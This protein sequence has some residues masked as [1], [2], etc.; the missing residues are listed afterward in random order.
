[1]SERSVEAI[2]SQYTQSCSVN[3]NLL[4]SVTP[5]HQ[6]NE[7]LETGREKSQAFGI[8]GCLPAVTLYEAAVARALRRPKSPAGC[9]DFMLL[10][11]I[12]III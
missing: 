4:P 1:M 3:L 11:S 2:H 12:L 8:R 9:F 10:R 6:K 5:L 7:V